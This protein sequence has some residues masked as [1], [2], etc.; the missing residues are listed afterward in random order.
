ML[1]ITRSYSAGVLGWMVDLLARRQ[2]VGLA[3]ANS[4]PLVA[5]W[6]GRIARLGTNPLAYAVPRADGDPLVFDMAT[7]GTAYVNI[8]RA[9]EEDRPIPLGWALDAQG[10]PTEDPHRAL[11]G[12]VAPLGGAK[13]FGLGLLVEIFAAGLS[14]A[15]W[16]IDSS[17]FG[18]DVGGP[19]G[20]GQTFIAI[21]PHRGAEPFTARRVE[22]LL[23]TLTSEDGVRLPGERRHASR[24][25]AEQHGVEVPDE[26]VE[27]IQGLG[28]IGS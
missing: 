2:L 7:T 23:T 19:P 25:H 18:D 3:F 28:R 16:G 20:V 27:Q 21:D 13:G 6:G 14:G 1:T 11:E 12:T 24:Q 26:L 22:R 15:N 17:S 5:P 8:V 10:Q 4:S 9:A